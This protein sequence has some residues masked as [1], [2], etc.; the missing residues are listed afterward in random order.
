MRVGKTL[1][2]GALLALGFLVA[3]DDA[4]AQQS[5]APSAPEVTAE[6]LYDSPEMEVGTSSQNQAVAI[7]AKTPEE[8]YHEFLS[9]RGM[10]DG[11]NF[12]DDGTMFFVAFDESGVEAKQNTW[13]QMRNI[14][15]SKAI[16]NAKSQIADFVAA[17]I[18]SERASEVLQLGGDIAPPAV[19]EAAAQLSV[20]DKALALT[21]KALDAEI[22]KFDPTWDGTG[23][24]EEQRRERVVTMQ[25]QYKSALAARSRLFLSGALPVFQAEGN[26]I[27]GRYTVGA[28]LVWSPRTQLVASA[29]T[30]D[31]VHLPLDAP[32][33][34]I[35]QQLQSQMNA[36]PHFLASSQGVR[37]WTNEKGEQTVVSFASIDRTRSKQLNNRKAGAEARK[38]IGQFVA[39]MVATAEEGSEQLTTQRLA[40]GEEEAFNESEFSTK[41]ESK[42][43]TIK[44]QGVAKVYS[45]K[46][47]HPESNANMQVDVYAWTPLG[48]GMANGLQHMSNTQEAR[49]NR[50]GASTGQQGTATNAVGAT[51]RMGAT[52]SSSKW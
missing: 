46:G 5:G 14:A 23:K 35:R 29:I 37:I 45:W 36:D 50:H 27:D 18:G 1:S 43:K 34:P 6:Q 26:D 39:E 25:E 8:Q 15:Y 10:H 4:L 3:Q 31:A 51:T 21:D 22:K 13:V 11:V 16:L 9:Q 52:T 47:K 17:E 32:E 49:M 2:A 44:L 28:A 42:A 38:M 20:M 7:S 24:T 33:P 48:R 19:K 40:N 41:V 12:R 30:S